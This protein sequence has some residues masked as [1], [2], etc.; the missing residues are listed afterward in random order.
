MPFLWLSYGLFLAIACS[1]L[2]NRVYLWLWKPRAPLPPGPPADL[3]IGHL[4]Y[5]PASEPD[6]AFYQ[7]GKQYGD[8]IHL[9]ILGR[10]TIVV[11]SF[12]RA[13][14]LLDKRSANYSD[15]FLPKALTE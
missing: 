1:L 7:L 13:V 11:N 8:I 12:Q 14:D 10:M 6:V 2:L 5:A 9:N 3:L 4:R 15:R